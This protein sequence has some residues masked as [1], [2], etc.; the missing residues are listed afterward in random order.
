M[1]LFIGINGFRNGQLN[2]GLAGKIKIWCEVIIGFTYKSLTFGY[3]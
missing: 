1:I 2:L 3:S